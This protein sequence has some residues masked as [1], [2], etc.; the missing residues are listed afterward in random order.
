MKQLTQ[1]VFNRPDCPEWA[2]WAAIDASSKAHWFNCEVMPDYATDSFDAMYAVDGFKM[3]LIGTGYDT[4][5]WEN[6][7]INREV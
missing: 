7:A 3:E 2:N 6:S 4:T 5:N 1:E